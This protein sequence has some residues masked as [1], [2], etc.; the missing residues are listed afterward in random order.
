MPTRVGKNVSINDVAIAAVSRNPRKKSG[1]GSRHR[2]IQKEKKWRRQGVLKAEATMIK[3]RGLSATKLVLSEVFK[4]A[5]ERK[6]ERGSDAGIQ[7]LVKNYKLLHGRIVLSETNKIWASIVIWRVAKDLGHPLRLKD[8]C[9]SYQADFG[10]AN[11]YKEKDPKT[12]AYFS[13]PE[14]DDLIDELEAAEDHREG[15]LFA[16]DHFCSG[17]S[18]SFELVL[19]SL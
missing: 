10:I 18:F 4:I 7:Y 5:A 12:Y 1:Q 13:P 15:K 14:L 11:A 9:D 19:F 3:G 16:L 2:E 8:V 6:I 17:N